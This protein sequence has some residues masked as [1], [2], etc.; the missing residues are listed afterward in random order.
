M[1]QKS[2]SRKLIRHIVLVLV[3]FIVL[4]TIAVISVYL[5]ET[6][7]S[8]RSSSEIVLKS[9]LEKIDNMLAGLQDSAA[10]LVINETIWSDIIMKRAESIDISTEF[11]ETISMLISNFYYGNK[12]VNKALIYFPQFE[13][14]YIQDGSQIEQTSVYTKGVSRESIRQAPWY[15]KAVESPGDYTYVMDEDGSLSIAIA[16]K[17]PYFDQISHVV[18]YNVVAEY[19][20]DLLG[21]T[22]ME[23]ETVLLYNQDKSYYYADDPELVD[24]LNEID[25]QITELSMRSGSFVFK[26]RQAMVCNYSLSSDSGWTLAKFIPRK[27]VNR[28][29]I[30]TMLL[31]LALGLLFAIPFLW[32]I[33]RYI[34][35]FTMPIVN[36]ADSMSRTG[37]D[38][39][40][41]SEAY[42][43]ND[44]VGVLYKKYGELMERI[45]YYIEH[46]H[47]IELN[48]RQ[49]QLDALQRQVNPHFIYNVLQ[50]LSNI[51]IESGNED[52]E[53]ICDAFGLLL[54]YNM[55]NINK[56][57][58]V[59]EEIDAAQKYLYILGMRYDDKLNAH[60]QV[61]KDCEKCR[62]IPFIIQ[63]ILENALDHGLRNKIAQWKLDLS[64]YREEDALMIRVEDNGIGMP[65][66]MVARLN[67]GM[68]EAALKEDIVG[69]K[70][71]GLIQKRIQSVYG[72]EYGIRV[73]S[74]FNIGTTITIRLPY[75]QG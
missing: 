58:L 25:G 13:Q 32:V 57:V 64:I 30:Q 12:S 7:K 14:L 54:R 66:E 8:Y 61:E 62:I 17:N 3:T 68:G 2:I 40:H 49:L 52:I 38:N 5:R 59:I 4:I 37:K 27:T 33:R 73:E 23:D 42:H 26:G 39:F 44:E 36:L 21:G 56:E 72:S 67:G 60:I 65:A 34:R 20:G 74:Y 43:E 11:Y 9:S 71:L 22:L 70:G 75:N 47:K 28:P 53:R 69:G 29:I 46:E 18:K 63:P 51:A 15:A 45:N 48:R 24:A 50:L 6:H 31:F 55:A 1:K 10:L 35:K 16:I 41:L 19:I